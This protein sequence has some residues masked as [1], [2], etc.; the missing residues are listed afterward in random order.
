MNI[1]KK[2]YL[3]HLL[4]NQKNI[5]AKLSG[6]PYSTHSQSE[7]RTQMTS[8]GVYMDHLPSSRHSLHVCGQK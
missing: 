5:A 3:T 1:C 6:E 8:R 4:I 7:H 2:L